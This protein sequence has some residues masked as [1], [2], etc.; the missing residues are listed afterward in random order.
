MVQE[1]LKELK[2]YLMEVFAFTYLMNDIT[3]VFEVQQQGCS[4][5]VQEK[6]GTKGT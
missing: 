3:E 6:R 1:L 4:T 5:F 2:V